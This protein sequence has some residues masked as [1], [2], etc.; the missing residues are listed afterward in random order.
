MDNPFDTPDMAAGYTRSRPG[1]HPLIIERLA[2]HLGSE[3]PVNGALDVGCGAGLSTQALGAIA[4]RPIGLDPSRGMVE[5]ARTLAPSA[6]FLVGVA[7]AMPVRERSIVLMTAAGSLNWVDLERFFPEVE[8]V[9]AP[10]GRLV[11]Y[12]FAA[13]SEFADDDTLSAWF[14]EFSRR[15]PSPPR[16]AILP[17]Q[18]DLDAHGLTVEHCERFVIALEMDP[19]FYLE[20]VLTQTNVAEAVRCGRSRESVRAWC[21]HTLGP[22]FATRRAVL[23][24]AYLA[25]VRRQPP[26][27]AL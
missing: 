24:R 14:A 26:S 15:Y 20:Y 18:L 25:V 9:L 21:A 27:A 23:F 16:R 22:I 10:H 13:G 6:R 7:E 17:E 1:V 11:I 3:T 8:R 12:D 5:Q 19:A 2:V 4:K